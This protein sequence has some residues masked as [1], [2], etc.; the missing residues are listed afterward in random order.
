LEPDDVPSAPYRTLKLLVVANHPVTGALSD[1]HDDSWPA[2]AGYVAQ[3]DVGGSLAQ[4]LRGVALPDRMWI[5]E[6]RDHAEK[7]VAS[8]LVF[9]SGRDVTVPAESDLEAVHRIPFPVDLVFAGVQALALWSWERSK[10][11]PSARTAPEQVG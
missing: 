2:W 6:F 11:H 7:R 3:A 8:D 10:R 5:T 9:R 1:A 4:A